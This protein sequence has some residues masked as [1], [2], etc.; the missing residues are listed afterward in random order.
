[1]TQVGSL[2]Q[3]SSDNSGF[4]PIDGIK[5]VNYWKSRFGMPEEAFRE[6]RFYR[7]AKSI[8]MSS[9]V[10]LPS[11]FYE[12]VGIRVLSLNEN[13]WKPTTCALQILGRYA[14]KNFIDLG[15]EEARI[16]MAGESQEIQSQ[17]EPG[18]VVVSHQ[19]QVLGCGLYSR[20][21]LISQIPKERRIQ[22]GSYREGSGCSEAGDL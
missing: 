16:F 20:G 6:F 5:A 22:D 10:D 12:T 4:C 14:T 13:L 7:R 18:Y 2:S 21:K 15:K 1:M 8:W 9:D 19:G 11:L 3:S 17:A